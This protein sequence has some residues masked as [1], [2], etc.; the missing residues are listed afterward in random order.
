MLVDD[1]FPQDRAM[2]EVAL[3]RGEGTFI[4]PRTGRYYEFEPTAPAP[5]TK[6]RYRMVG[7]RPVLISPAKSEPIKFGGETYRPGPQG[8]VDSKNRPADANTA[9]ILDRAQAQ[10]T[11][12]P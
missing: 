7:G 11:K 3:R 8:W 1:L 2:L 5:L 12:S 6:P 9:Q 10:A 4:D